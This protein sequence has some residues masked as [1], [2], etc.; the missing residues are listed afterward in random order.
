[1][2]VAAG[3]TP[4]HGVETRR[5]FWSSLGMDSG[6]GTG[7]KIALINMFELFSDGR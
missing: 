7:L 5:Q 2:E 6:P 4:T 3:S 1:M